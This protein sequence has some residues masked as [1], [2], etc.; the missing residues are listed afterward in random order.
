[1]KCDTTEFRVCTVR[2]VGVVLLCFSYSPSSTD[3]IYIT[4]LMLQHKQLYDETYVK[5]G[6]KIGPPLI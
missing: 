1:M 5:I 2:Y 4:K 3:H 6:L